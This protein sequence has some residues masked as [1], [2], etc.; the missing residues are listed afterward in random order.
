MTTRR[1]LWRA[2]AATIA[3][4]ATMAA[5]TG[6][7]HGQSRQATAAAHRQTTP[8]SMRLGKILHPAKKYYGVYVSRA[9]SSLAPIR[10]VTKETGKQ[11]N[12]SLYYADWG[13]GAAAG[14][15][16]FATLS[17]QNACHAGMLPMMTWESWNSTHTGTQGPRVTQPAFAPAKI[18]HG[19]YDRYVR[20]T[21]R[22]IR[23]IKCPIALRL[24]QEVNS[25]WYPWGVAT[26]GMHNSPHDYVAMWRHVWHIFHS[27]HANNV[28]WVWTP[29][30]QS[31]KHPGLPA[32]AKS[33]PGNKYVDWVGIDGYFY[34]RPKETFHDLF[35]S[36]MKQLSTFAGR[37]PWIIAE[38]GVGSGPTKPQQITNLL[39][40]VARSKRLDGVNYFDT[41]KPWGRSDWRFD[42]TS[43]SLKAFKAGINRTA[44]GAGKPGVIP[45]S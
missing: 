27:V 28:V 36:T 42:Q 17:A 23:A 40:A 43:A 7:A 31:R 38:C 20:A 4:V 2:S 25:N 15:S 45:S 37:K 30:V 3:A 33:Y 13:P 19:K 10:E 44:F 21:A 12:L 16:N 29:N 9:P 5:G 26:P 22:A 8:R 6:A 1:V 18:A 39:A 11:P 41:D 34:N 32:L 24:D 14:Y 35:G